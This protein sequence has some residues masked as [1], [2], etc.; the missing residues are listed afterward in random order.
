MSEYSESD[1]HNG[2]SMGRQSGIRLP[3]GNIIFEEPETKFKKIKKIFNPIYKFFNPIYKFFIQK[4]S[5]FIQSHF[6]L[7]LLII[8]TLCILINYLL[9]KI[10][11]DEPDK[12]EFARTTEVKNING[13]EKTIHRSSPFTDAI[14]YSFTTFSTV[15]YGDIIPKTTHAKSWTIFMH[16]L[17]M[18][19]SYKLFEY[20]YNP[21]SEAIRPVINRLKELSEANQIL[22]KDK[23][24]YK[25]RLTTVNN[26]MKS[27]SSQ[28]DSMAK[29][30]EN[31]T[32]A[33]EKEKEENIKLTKKL[34]VFTPSSTSNTTRSNTVASPQSSNYSTKNDSKKLQQ[35]ANKIAKT[36]IL[37][38][39]RRNAEAN[40]KIIP[41]SRQTDRFYDVELTNKENSKIARIL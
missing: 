17:V 19:I 39:N 22:I 11:D 35:T 40:N 14:H 27:V 21:N 34:E 1:S 3:V 30:Y 33:L 4:P 25:Y 29:K 9:F 16:S 32:K 41:E 10:N 18:Y 6:I 2:K 38:N 23:S 13:E 12:C 20:V 15:G 37:F 24:N 5:Y 8:L 7:S 31:I 26:E 28:L 36:A